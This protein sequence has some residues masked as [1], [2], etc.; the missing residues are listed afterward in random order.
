MIRNKQKPSFACF[1][2]SSS[3]GF[4]LIE[5]LFVMAIFIIVI[6]ISSEAFNKILS[7]STQQIKSSESDIQ[8]VVGL[9]IMRYDLEHAGYG[10][11]WMLS[12]VAE[13][14]EAVV[15]SLAPGIDRQQ[16][17]DK[18]NSSSDTNKVP[19]AVQAAASPTD[20][21][22]YLVIKSVL[23]GMSD[24]TQR[25]EKKWTFVD[26]IGGTSSLK[27]WESSNFVPGERVITIDSR[28]KRLV[29][30]SILPDDFSYA[31]TTTTMTPPVRSA[32]SLANFQP[33]QDTDVFVVYGVSP[34]TDLRVPY[35]RVDYYVKQPASMPA[36]CAPGTGNLYKAV[37]NHAGGDFKEFSLV[38]CVADM[39]VIFSLDSNGDGEVDAHVGEDGLTGLSAKEIRTQLKEI[40]VYVVAHEGGKDLSYSHSSADI[41]VNE[42]GAG[43]ILHLNTLVGDDYK[44][45]RWKVY[46]M[47]VVPRNIN[48]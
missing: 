4:T 7:V 8:G 2:V 10:L 43:R 21:R 47:V 3:K 41:D 32:P 27:T 19:R 26:G 5:L 1:S 18:N 35:N 42:F 22:D 13:F 30:T 23:A 24:I 34:D 46:R 28:S 15:G 38:E 25:T 33:Q 11:P 44:Y 36:R 29:G 17:N 48:Y 40:R 45:Y 20:G 37:M 12:F 31:I 16:F 9:E 14:D 6:I 39:Q